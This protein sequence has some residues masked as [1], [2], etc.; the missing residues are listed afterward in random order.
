M[1]NTRKKRKN[2]VKKTTP[3][4][5]VELI[6]QDDYFYFIAGYTDGGAPYGITWEE[7][8]EIEYKE[9]QREQRIETK[10]ETYY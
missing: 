6:E 7:Q 8:E 5:S 2:R 3:E 4:S 1:S 10:R 9:R